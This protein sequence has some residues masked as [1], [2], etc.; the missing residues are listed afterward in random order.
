MKVSK[1]RK[2]PIGLHKDR[3]RANRDNPKEVEF[4]KQWQ[5]EHEYSDLL[6]QLL[7]GELTERD[8]IVAETIVQWLGSSVG[9]NMLSQA[10]GKDF[11]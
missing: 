6:F 11:E 2:E 4:V 10:L 3:L 9:L 8:R 1:L 7:E 5:K